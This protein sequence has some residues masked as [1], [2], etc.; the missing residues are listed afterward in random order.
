MHT[1]REFLKASSVLALGASAPAFWR[2]VAFAAPRADQAGAKDTVLVI[3]QLSGGNDGLNTVIPYRDADY[4]VARPK[5]KQPVDRVKKINGDL[6]FHPSM[7]GFAKLLEQ[8]QLGIVQGVGY[9]NPNR[10]HFDSMDIWHKASFS[11]SEP[12]GWLG[13]TCDKLG[14]NATALHIGSDDSPLALVGPTARSSSLRSLAE[15]QL[16]VS[17][18]GDDPAK[19]R[20]IEKLADAGSSAS[21]SSGLLDLVKQS[22]RQTYQSAEK[23][24]QVGRD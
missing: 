4:A 10:S 15:Y 19:R 18:Q 3:V 22:A 7:S 17:Q 5:L 6:A 13:R 11:K 14:E 20:V 1:R 8:S 2:Q 21:N 9:P 23:L 16:K 12:F 24:R